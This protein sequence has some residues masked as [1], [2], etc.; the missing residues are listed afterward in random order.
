MSND[1]QYLAHDLTLRL[2]PPVGLCA[3]GPTKALHCP[4]RTAPV[5]FL[6]VGELPGI[7][8]EFRQVKCAWIRVKSRVALAIILAALLN[9]ALDHTPAR[10][11]AA[12]IGIAVGIGGLLFF[13]HAS[14]RY[15]RARRTAGLGLLVRRAG[16]EARSSGEL[17]HALKQPAAMAT[18]NRSAT[19]LIRARCLVGSTCY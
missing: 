16:R 6:G 19:R 10:L 4:A 9:I 13:L 7:D 18:A 5:Q 15:L 12:C 8:N 17:P 14:Q 11:P 1:Q 2:E 3:L